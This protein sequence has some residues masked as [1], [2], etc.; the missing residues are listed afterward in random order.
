MFWLIE[1]YIFNESFIVEILL[2]Y[3]QSR[4]KY[5]LLHSYK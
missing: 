2:I 4:I 1:D 5:E 3:F